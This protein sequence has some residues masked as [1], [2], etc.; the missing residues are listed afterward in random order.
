MARDFNGNFGDKVVVA[1]YAAIDDLT[2]LTLSMWMFRVASPK[3]FKILDMDSEYEFGIDGVGSL[4]FGAQ[5]WDMTV[6]DW[7]T[8]AGVIPLNVWK[9][10]LL[11]Y[12]YSSTANNPALFIN[13]VSTAIPVSTTPVGMTAATGVTSL[14]IGND[15]GLFT[16]FPGRL[17]EFAMYNIVLGAND[18]T[19]LGNGA[20]VPRVRPDALVA[21]L[22]LVG[23]SPEAN[24]APV[25]GAN[26]GV[27]T[28]TTV[29]D[30]PPI[31]PV[32]GYDVSPTDIGA[33]VAVVG[34][35]GMNA[36]DVVDAIDVID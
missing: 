35:G 5:R 8:A 36:V 12:D 26:N 11:T 27:V 21:Y 4:D 18:I 1:E 16:P 28:T 24:Y 22:P 32:W 6:G 17:A 25:A 15:S 31:T 3:G 13:G 30:G 29:V 33:V 23:G 19:A 14:F 34:G 10:V 2:T 20:P 7:V 9:H